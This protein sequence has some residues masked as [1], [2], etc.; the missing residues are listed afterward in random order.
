MKMSN[1]LMLKYEKNITKSDGEL[2]LEITFNL[3]NNKNN[4]DYKFLIT[5]TTFVLA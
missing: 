1:K 3:L 2:K 4:I 5:E